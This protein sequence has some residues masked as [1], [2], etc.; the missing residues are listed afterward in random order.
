MEDKKER[1]G[2]EKSQIIK[3]EETQEE[4]TQKEN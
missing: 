1:F 4:I 2:L 3:L